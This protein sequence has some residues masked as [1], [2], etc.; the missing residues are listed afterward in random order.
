ML[1]SQVLNGSS[2]PELLTVHRCVPYLFSSRLTAVKREGC[3]RK[4]VQISHGVRRNCI[5]LSISPHI[6]PPLQSCSTVEDAA[7]QDNAL[8]R[9]GILIY[10]FSLRHKPL[11]GSSVPPCNSSTLSYPIYQLSPFPP[12][13]LKNGA[14]AA[15]RRM[16]EKC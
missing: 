11:R 14:E 2:M 13:D 7:S 6:F 12:R 10:L 5:V 15:T 16:L 4:G 8:Q 9:A 3:F 1:S